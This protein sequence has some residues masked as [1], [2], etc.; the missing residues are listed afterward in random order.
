MVCKILC[1]DGMNLVNV[2]L[3]RG[4]HD[5]TARTTANLRFKPFLLVCNNK[6]SLLRHSPQLLHFQL[7]FPNHVLQRPPRLEPPDTVT[8]VENQPRATMKC[9][10]CI[11]IHIR[12][13]LRNHLF[14]HTLHNLQSPD[15]IANDK[16]S[17]Q[18]TLLR[19]SKRDNADHLAQQT[20]MQSLHATS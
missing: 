8:M 1:V 2:V 19:A 10:C 18:A 13:H 15:C 17:R 9:K 14:N 4:K 16:P 7:N 12:S 3:E 20:A 6:F 5:T 11:Q